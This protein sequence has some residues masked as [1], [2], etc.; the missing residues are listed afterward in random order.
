MKSQMQKQVCESLAE[1]RR[2]LCGQ[3]RHDPE[4]HANNIALAIQELI[5]ASEQIRDA[6]RPAVRKT[7]GQEDE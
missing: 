3:F 7:G 5:A 6:E 2:L 1:A 4:V